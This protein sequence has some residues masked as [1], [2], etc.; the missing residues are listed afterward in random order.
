M[1]EYILLRISIHAPRVGSD[2]DGTS[3]TAGRLI[4]IHAPRVGSDYPL[5]PWQPVLGHISIHAPRVGSDVAFYADKLNK[6]LFQS[7]LPVWGATNLRSWPTCRI[8]FQSTLPVWGAT[9]RFPC[10]MR[11]KCISIHAPR[12]GSDYNLSPAR[13]LSAYFNPR[14]PCGERL[15]YVKVGPHS[16]DFNPRSPCGE[17]RMLMPW[18]MRSCAI[19]I[20]APRVGSDFRAPG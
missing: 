9:Q 13:Y 12:V 16:G 7:T 4:S 11:D 15:V 6:A 10:E 18:Q 8:L 19:S 20:H 1:P 14:S 17:R 5:Q 3:V 2:A